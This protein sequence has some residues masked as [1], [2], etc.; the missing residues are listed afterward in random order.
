LVDGQDISTV[1]LRI[2]R[3]RIGIIP[4]DPVL[5]AATLRFNLDPLDLYSDL[6]L[7]SALEA[8]RLKEFVQGLEGG[9][10]ASVSEAGANFSAG[11]RQLICF[12]RSLL[13]RPKIL[14]LDEVGHW[15]V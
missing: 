8:V 7:W 2:L 4:Q 9:L 3:S 13:R 12:A 1:P 11:Q 10:N 14:I 6:E 5:W 15:S